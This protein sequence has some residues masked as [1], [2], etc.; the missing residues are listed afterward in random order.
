[1]KYHPYCRQPYWLDMSNQSLNQH[2]RI[3]VNKKRNQ[4]ANLENI[5]G[6]ESSEDKKIKF[7]QKYN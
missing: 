3:I 4:E 6:N 2:C 7:N 5:P 1:M